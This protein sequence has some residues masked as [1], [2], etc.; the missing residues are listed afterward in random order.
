MN[1]TYAIGLVL[2]VSAIV[3]IPYQPILSMVV[4]LCAVLTLGYLLRRLL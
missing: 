2:I 1:T 4:A 3:L